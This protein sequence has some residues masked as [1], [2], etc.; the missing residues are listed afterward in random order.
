ML[1]EIAHLF[2]NR[3]LAELMGEREISFAHTGFYIVVWALMRLKIGV[4]RLHA[5]G[6]DRLCGQQGCTAAE[7]T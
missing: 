5:V 6:L 7:I 3:N 2:N 4:W 1:D